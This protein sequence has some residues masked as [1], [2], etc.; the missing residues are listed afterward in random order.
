MHDASEAYLQ[1]ISKPLKAH[2]PEY[3]VIETRM[4]ERMALHFGFAWPKS[5]EVE[6]ADKAA[7]EEEWRDIMLGNPEEEEFITRAHVCERF[8][9]HYHR[10]KPTP[11]Q[12]PETATP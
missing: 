5:I 11:K 12:F 4:M 8:L 7:M 3:K 6:N 2:L 9:I 10:F 1:D